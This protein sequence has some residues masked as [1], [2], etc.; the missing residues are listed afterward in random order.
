VIVVHI[1]TSRFAQITISHTIY[2]KFVE[3]LRFS[4]QNIVLLKS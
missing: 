1:L 3:K 4:L 2:R